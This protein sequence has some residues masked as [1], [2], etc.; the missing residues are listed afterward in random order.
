LDKLQTWL[1]ELRRAHPGHEKG[2][3]K[4]GIRKMIARLQEDI[5]QYEGSREIENAFPVSGRSGTGGLQRE[6]DQGAVLKRR[7]PHGLCRHVEPAAGAGGT[8]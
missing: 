6:A 8:R 7:G 2:L 3:T 5:G 1:E 4:A